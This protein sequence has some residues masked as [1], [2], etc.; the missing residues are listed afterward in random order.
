MNKKIWLI[1]WIVFPNVDYQLYYL[2]CLAGSR[3]WRLFLIA[4]RISALRSSASACNTMR[5]FDVDIFYI[6]VFI[7]SFYFSCFCN[8]RVISSI[9]YL[10]LSSSLSKMVC[11][12]YKFF[13]L[14]CSFC[15]TFLCSLTDTQSWWCIFLLLAIPIKS[16]LSRSAIL[17]WA[18]L[19]C[20]VST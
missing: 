10:C 8:F 12:C 5:P 7:F 13:S 16:S 18:L 1:I 20:W 19:S 9:S 4:W 15:V 2:A 6:S 11:F 3:F 14:I 17:S